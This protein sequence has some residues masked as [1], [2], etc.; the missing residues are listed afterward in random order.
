[1]RK[2]LRI[3]FCAVAGLVTSIAFA[4]TIRYEYVVNGVIETVNYNPGWF[5]TGPPVDPQLAVRRLKRGSIPFTGYSFSFDDNSGTGSFDYYNDNDA[6]LEELTV[7]IMPGG[8]DSLESAF[9]GCGINSDVTTMPFSDCTITEFGTDASSTVITFFGAPGLPA[10]SHFEF[11]LTGFPAGG[12]VSVSAI[13][14]VTP[15]PETL[16]LILT[17]AALLGCAR[18]FRKLRSPTR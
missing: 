2:S 5:D 6:I 9:F 18:W 4:D 11:E 12:T 7:T 3:L 10:F 16:F 15:E 17:G 8:P 1:M 14:E 13:P